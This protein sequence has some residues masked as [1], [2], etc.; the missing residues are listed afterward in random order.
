MTSILLIQDLVLQQHRLARIERL[1][2]EHNSSTGH[3]RCINQEAF[4]LG[5]NKKPQKYTDMCHLDN[6]IAEE[7]LNKI[8]K[9]L[10][11]ITITNS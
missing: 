4:F 9:E 2:G 3:L 5:T 1:F 7:M 11:N 6:N 10:I 8:K